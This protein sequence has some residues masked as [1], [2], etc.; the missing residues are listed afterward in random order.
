MRLN[1]L[2]EEVRRILDKHSIT[3]PAQI[4]V[5]NI[6]DDLNAEIRYA[7][8]DGCAANLV[9]VG[10]YAIITVDESASYRR[11]RFSIAHELAHWKLDRKKDLYICEKKDL[12]TPWGG[13]SKLGNSVEK[14]ANMFAAELLMPVEMF[15]E[16]VR[17]QPVT[18]DTVEEAGEEFTTSRT[19]T[20]IRLV[21]HGSYFAMLIS[22][23]ARKRNRE[24]YFPSAD[25]PINL[26]PHQILSRSSNAWIE[27][28]RKGYVTSEPQEVDGTAWID[29]KRAFDFT[30]TEQAIR[31]RDSILVLICWL[32]DAIIGELSYN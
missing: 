29:H 25:L 3:S 14:R 12:N 21:E 16:F 8:L 19:S 2:Q 5:E 6:A 9:G 31:V 15:R 20:A 10:D 1:P 27:I 22:Y 13:R 4:D 7:R 26:Y 18:F 32:D 28:V 11:K 30:V 23:N 24:W 17:D